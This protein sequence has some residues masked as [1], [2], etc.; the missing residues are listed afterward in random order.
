MME[1]RFKKRRFWKDFENRNGFLKGKQIQ[2]WNMANKIFISF[3]QLKKQNV[4]KI[5]L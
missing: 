3:R 5:S 2:I 1:M 4:I